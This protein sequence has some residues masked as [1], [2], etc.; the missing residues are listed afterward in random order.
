MTRPALALVTT[1]LIALTACH[2]QDL[3]EGAAD[4]SEAAIE[5]RAQALETAATEES[6]DAMANADAAP[7]GIEAGSNAY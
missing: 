5:N 7:N 2:R 4:N 1:L 6:R 3:G